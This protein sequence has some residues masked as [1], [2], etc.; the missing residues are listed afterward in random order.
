M[1]AEK[2]GSR[3]LPEVLEASKRLQSRSLAVNSHIA[4]I[5]EKLVKLRDDIQVITWNVEAASLHAEVLFKK[6]LLLLAI[7]CLDRRGRV[8]TGMRF[9]QNH[10]SGHE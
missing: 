1:E 10:G 2:V 4:S 7:L 3:S 8:E 5:D 9:I 6:R